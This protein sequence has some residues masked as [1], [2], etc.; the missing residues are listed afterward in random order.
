MSTAFGDF[1][2]G[3][4]STWAVAAGLAGPIFTFGAIEGQV[5]TAEAG[6]REA[7]AF[8]QRTVLNAFRETNDALVG[9]VKKRE[10]SEAQ[11]RRVAALR[12]YAR[13]SRLRFDNGYAGYLE[14]LYAE[15]ELFSAELTAVRSQA[16]RYTQIVNVY[17]AVGGGWVDEADKLAP[18]PQLAR[19]S[20]D[21]TPTASR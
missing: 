7:L 9:T 11:A 2:S 3:P 13:L 10:E 18:Q 21:G 8:Y 5:Q 15:N 20:G 19:P 1:L 16:E 6:D 12:E 17:Q 4:A 14:V